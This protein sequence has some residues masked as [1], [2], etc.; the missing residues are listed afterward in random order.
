MALIGFL[1]EDT[2]CYAD[3][4]ADHQPRRLLQEQ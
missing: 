3:A 4:A 2:A 1:K